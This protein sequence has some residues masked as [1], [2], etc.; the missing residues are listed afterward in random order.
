MKRAIAEA[1]YHGIRSNRLLYPLM[2]CLIAM[3]LAVS[4][5]SVRAAGLIRDAEI[6]G[7]I[8][9]YARP[10][11]Q[12]AG[13]GTQNIRI[14]LV[15]DRSF[16]AFVVD[17]NNMFMHV[18]ALMTAKTPNQVIGVLAHETGHIAGGHLARLRQAVSQA[19]SA[20]LMYRLLGIA[21]IAAGAATGAGG[22]LGKAGSALIFGGDSMTARSLLAYRR[23][24]ESAADQAAISYLNATKQSARGMLDTFSHFA[25]QGLASLKYVDPYLQSH[26]MPQQRIAQLRDMA[27]ASPYFDRRDPPELQAR[28][29]M[30][31]AKLAGFLENPRTVFNLYPKSNQT[32][33]AQYAR[34]IAVYRQSGLRPFLPAVNALIAAHPDNP[35]FLE[36]KGQFLFKSG[37]AR[38]AI[39]PLRKSVSLA[40][41]AGLIRILLA[42]ALLGE[43]SS[44]NVDEA[45]RHLRNAL[46]KEDRSATGYRQ[47]ATAY[48]LKRRVADA[49]LAS[50]HAYLYEGNLKLA[51]QQAQRAR[52]KFKR[53]TPSW[54]KA[55]DIINF[56]P[57]E[58]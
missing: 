20:S 1:A 49:E 15:N 39:P 18:G 46:V 55:D 17:G 42:Q 23:A 58:R 24:E 52:G 47:L 35:Y 21:A 38:E 12:V 25:D 19:R 43:P 31:R 5:T 2:A 7:L 50:A 48:A 33:P 14:H 57:P 8:R 22:D 41:K 27:R 53:G 9:D 51:K 56:R 32:L 13:V 37:K 11:F 28:H 44:A 54:I 4:S 29:E 6:E 10:I 16:N 26:P 3:A 40:P 34:T 36:L 30:M 45:I